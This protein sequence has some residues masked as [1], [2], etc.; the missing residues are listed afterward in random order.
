MF[1]VMR[2]KLLEGFEPSTH[3]IFAGVMGDRYVPEPKMQLLWSDDKWRADLSPLVEVPLDVK[4]EGSALVAPVIKL[5][6][7]ATTSGVLYYAC[8]LSAEYPGRWFPQQAWPMLWVGGERWSN[9]RLAGNY[10][11]EAITIGGRILE[12]R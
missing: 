6:V 12:L 9:G 7:G 11:Q 8:P 2:E 5:H 1:D 10:T 4:A 3:Q